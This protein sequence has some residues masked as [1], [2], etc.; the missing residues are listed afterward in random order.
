MKVIKYLYRQSC[1]NFRRA[2][3]EKWKQKLGSSATYNNL[4]G[5]FERAGYQE[6]ADA[7]RKLVQPQMSLEVEDNS[8]LNLVAPSTTQ[9]SQE[10]VFPELPE[11]SS[12]SLR[13]A[14]ATATA[15]LIKQKGVIAVNMVWHKPIHV[16]IYPAYARTMSK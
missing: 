13:V 9:L 10:P 3:L 2:A 14:T 5:V 8:K 11:S 6:Y 4:I 15:V 7:V 1:F 12:S 16:T